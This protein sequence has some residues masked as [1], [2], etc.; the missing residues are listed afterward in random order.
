[1]D[2][3]RQQD[4][5]IRSD[6]V[7]QPWRTI[8][9]DSLRRAGY[10]ITDGNTSVTYYAPGLD[11]LVSN[12]FVEDHCFHL[13]SDKRR[14]ELIG[15]AFEPSADRKRVAEIKGTVWLDRKTSELRS[16][17]YK[18]AN[19]SADQ[20]NI[21]SGA[22]EFVRMTNGAW[23]ISRWNIR[24]PVVE[25][26]VRR[27]FGAETRVAEIHVA[28]GELALAR[29]GTDTLWSRPPLEISGSVVDSTSGSTIAKAKVSLR[30]T[31]LEGTTDDRGRFTI[32]GVLPGE[33]SVDV[34]TPSLDSANAVHQS[35]IVV[36]DASAPVRIR[37]PNAAQIQTVLCGNQRLTAPGIVFGSASIRG[38]TAPP[39]GITVTAQWTD[40]AVRGGSAGVG[41]DKL[42]R[43]IETRVAPDGSFRLCGVPVNSALAILAVSGSTARGEM[44]DVRIPDDK[45]FARVDLVLERG[46]V[47]AVFQGVVVTDSTERPIAAAEV[48]IPEI[49]KTATTNEKGAFRVDGIP[50]GTHKIVIRR[51]GFGPAETT[52]SFS[53]N[54]IVERRVVLGRVVTLEPVR[55]TET[56]F[57]RKM[58][59]FE[60]NRR[61][62]LGHFYTRAQ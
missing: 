46:A 2:R 20:E 35:S 48:S 61:I 55:V 4:S 21:A 30:G 52:L 53:A 27:G 13:T 3:V 22:L 7:T 39:R 12:L 18:Y 58:A 36:T 42:K 34:R 16:L 5:R 1:V 28:G 32:N 24:M 14:A 50:S 60:E 11:M 41:V 62:G 25:Q 49:G 23:A 37:A 51:I 57:E 15:I 26:V 43:A 6:H 10:V 38:D 45:R 8:S 31:Q 40:L 59:E 47:G 9:P 56:A 44:S 19:V 17:D 33:Y 29:R 54:Q